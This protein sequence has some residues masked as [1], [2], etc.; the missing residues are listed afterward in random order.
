MARQEQE[1]LKLSQLAQLSW[2]GDSRRILQSWPKPIM[3]DFGLALLD[4]Q[5][6]LRTRLPTRPMSSVGPGVFELK[7]SDAD[8]WYRVLY[9]ARIGNTIHILHSFTKDTAKTERNDINVARQRLK[10]VHERMRGQ[11]AK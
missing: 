10:L 7:D 2:E 5:Q 9:L 6:G 11:R 1:V 4:L 3:Q 8:K